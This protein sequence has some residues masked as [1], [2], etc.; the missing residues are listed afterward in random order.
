VPDPGDRRPFA[1]GLL[2]QAAYEACRIAIDYRTPVIL[3]STDRWPRQ[4][5]LAAAGS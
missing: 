4:R 2:R 5:A 3:L 1:R